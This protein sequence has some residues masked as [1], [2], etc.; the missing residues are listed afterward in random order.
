MKI[1]RIDSNAITNN[2]PVQ[3][4]TETIS[5]EALYFELSDA[6]LTDRPVGFD[7]IMHYEETEQT[8]FSATGTILLSGQEELTV[9]VQVTMSRSYVVDTETFS[10][11][12][13]LS[14][15]YDPLVINLEGTAAG[16]KAKP[17]DFDLNADG[18]INNGNEL[19]GAIT[20]NGFAD[21]ATYDEDENGWIDASD[22]VFNE[23]RLWIQ[24]DTGKSTLRSLEQNHI[25]AIYLKNV[26]T[27]FSVTDTGNESIHF[28]VEICI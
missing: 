17:F 8:I 6:I 19:F 13:G 25:G 20:G 10:P 28:L 16:L 26:A 18:I 12:R 7:Q 24:D 9:S 11:F 3:R 21:L 5:R 23:L 15:V 14:R 27:Q 22:W 4:G 1:K 2:Q